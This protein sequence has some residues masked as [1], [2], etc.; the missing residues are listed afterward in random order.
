MIPVDQ[1]LFDPKNPRI[2][3]NIDKSNERR[4]LEWMLDDATIIELMRSIGQNGYFNAE[5]LLV[6]E[7]KKHKNKYDVVEGNRRLSAVKLL[8]DPKLAPVKTKAVAEASR[9]AEVVPE[10]LPAIIYPKRENIIEYLGYRH[11][12]GIKAWD[13]LAKAKYLH[14]LRGTLKEKDTKKQ[15]QSLARTIGSNPPYVARLLTALAIYEEIEVNEF[16]DIP[17]LNEQTIDFSLI[18]T[19]LQYS[20]LIKFLGL[21]SNTDTSVKKLD[22]DNLKDLTTWFFERNEQNITR[23]G[24]SRHLRQLNAVVQN[25]TALR[26]FKRG[27]PLEDAALLTGHPAE[28]FRKALIKAQAQ[29]RYAQDHIHKIKTPA[30]EDADMLVEIEELASFLLVSI[31]R[32]LSKR[33]KVD[34]GAAKRRRA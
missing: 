32:S 21:L 30:A 8:R 29:L 3:S 26:L 5:P 13:S 23:L 34:V 27:A 28:V 33:D 7:S 24:E 4:V 20:G 22:I 11:I 1:L 15:F 10:T 16:F 31:Q 17:N 14:E 25:E 6:I 19:A 12:T 18:T 2:P 9:E